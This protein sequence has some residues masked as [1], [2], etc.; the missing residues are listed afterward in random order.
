MTNPLSMDL[1]ERAMARVAAGESVR[2]V[3]AVT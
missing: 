3:A 2:V 1:R